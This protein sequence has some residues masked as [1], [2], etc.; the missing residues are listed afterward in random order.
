MAY[1]DE[2]TVMVNNLKTKTWQRSDSAVYSPKNDENLKSVTVYGCVAHPWIM[3]RPLLQTGTRT[4]GEELIPFL[5]RILELR[6]DGRPD[7]K[8][9]LVMDRHSA[10]F[11][12]PTGVRTFIQNNFRPYFLPTAT[13]ELNSAETLFA[14]MKRYLKS[15]FLQYQA[16]IRRQELF[17]QE[18][19]NGLDEVMEKYT[20]SRLFFANMRDIH[21]TL[22]EVGELDLEP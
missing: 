8:M 20:D 9:V 6:R 4:R 7:Q 12:V 10:H 21:Q 16:R 19:E 18:L 3:D 15:F 5:R 22:V 11:G 2:T 13:S 1:I 14:V 17:F